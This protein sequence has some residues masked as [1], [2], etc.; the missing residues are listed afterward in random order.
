M[1]AGRPPKGP[2]LVEGLDA[3]DAVKE[4]LRIILET[5]TGETTVAKACEKLDVSESRFHQMREEALASA[6]RG[7]E[8]KPRGRP[9]KVEE[10][11]VDE[12]EALRREVEELREELE[13]AR[14][15]AVLAT[16]FP[17]LVKD[18]SDQ[19]KTNPRRE[20]RKKRKAE[21]KRKKGS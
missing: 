9:R 7:L 3:S 4:K 15:R 5:I 6:G 17:H 2:K 10:P 18:P 16:A 1:S 12:V 19:K 13:F 21:R 8:P 20:R 14:A 11:T